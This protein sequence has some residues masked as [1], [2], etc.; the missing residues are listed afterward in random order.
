M[1]T[2]FIELPLYDSP[3]YTYQVNLEGNSYGLRF[4]YNEVMQQTLLT[5]YNSKVEVLVAGVGLVPNYPIALEYVVPDLTGTFLLLPTFTT[6][7]EFYNT[8]PRNLQQYYTL[9]YAYNATV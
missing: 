1:T 5:I 8:Y 7:D 4:I 2:L 6:D 9:S 3:D